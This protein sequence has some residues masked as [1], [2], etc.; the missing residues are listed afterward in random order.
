MAIMIDIFD[1]QYIINEFH[2][3]GFYRQKNEYC[4]VKGNT[5]PIY[6]LWE[7]FYKGEFPYADN[8]TEGYVP[9]GANYACGF[10]LFISEP[11][12]N[13]VITAIVVWK[14]DNAYR[15]QAERIAEINNGEYTYNSV[16]NI[17]FM[18]S[19]YYNSSYDYKKLIYGGTNTTT[20]LPTKGAN[21]VNQS[22][23]LQIM[24]LVGWQDGV[25]TLLG[26][27]VC[28]PC[29]FHWDDD[30]RYYC[31]ALMGTYLTKNGVA[32]KNFNDIIISED[33][34]DT[35][36]MSR[37]MGANYGYY[38]LQYDAITAIAGT[39][40]MNNLWL[41]GYEP[42]PEPPEYPF[43]E[44]YNGGG[45]GTG[46]YTDTSDEI[47]IDGVPGNSAIASGFVNAY[48]LTQQN[49]LDFHS[50]LYTGSFT[51]NVAK[52]MSDPI[53]YI[54]GFMLA[55]YTPDTSASANIIIG[56]TD[57]E[58]NATRI[59]SGYK[60]VDCGSVTLNEFWGKF[61]D[62]NPYTK[63]QIYLPFIGVRPLD[64]DETMAG[65]VN[66]TYRIDVLTGDCVATVSVDNARGTK[67]AIYNFNGNCHA[68]IPVCGKNSLATGLNAAGNFVGMAA[69][70]A[71]GNV[72]MAVT[73]A[74]NT[75]K[76]GKTEVEHGGNLSG[77]CG[78]LANFTPF[79]IV[80]RP[81]QS[82][83]QNYNHYHGFISNITAQLSTLSGYTQVAELVQVNIHC[84]E[85]EFDEINALLKEG[86]YL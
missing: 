72:A 22:T 37:D 8:G 6:Q 25:C 70:I 40:P 66:L 51:Q 73:G 32:A 28:T 78:L 76:S 49:A 75:V 81:S 1:N 39:N 41:S 52:L 7:N 35:T 79:L 19:Q 16:I 21:Y 10:P 68:H 48:L 4:T 44:D 53:D 34:E 59:S 46:D 2:G 27:T 83:A 67:G 20:W 24:G 12:Q 5:I 33:E 17:A 15:T 56:G 23:T 26:K 71:T 55:P 61:Y 11:N 54:I 42:H 63:L 18:Q 62:Y 69:G 64:I 80:S 57:S 86:V 43:E 38:Y 47:P 65:N 85:T 3:A 36:N 45:G 58:V 9:F 74:I 13:N 60:T 84:T 14:V 30:P 82:L 29:W 50:Y 31:F 77:S